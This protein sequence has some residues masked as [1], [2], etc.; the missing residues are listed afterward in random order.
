MSRDVIRWHLIF[1]AQVLVGVLLALG[2]G[3]L[4]TFALKNWTTAALCVFGVVVY[5]YIAE[6]ARK[7]GV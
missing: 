6:I 5:I 3:A 1:A 4:I 7:G 2:A